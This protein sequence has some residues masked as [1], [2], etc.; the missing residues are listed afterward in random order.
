M[1]TLAI[2]TTSF[3]LIGGLEGWRRTTGVLRAHAAG[4]PLP[5]L[6]HPDDAVA[7]MQAVEL[8]HHRESRSVLRLGYFDRRVL[9]EV[10]LGRWVGGFATFRVR[11]LRPLPV[12]AWWVGAQTFAGLPAMPSTRLA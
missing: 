4:A 9:C 3:S 12:S 5:A 1:T 7:L 8:A 2:I 10:W 11:A 6:L